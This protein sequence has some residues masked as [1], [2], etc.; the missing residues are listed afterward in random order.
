MRQFSR[1]F[2]ACGLV[3]AALP[4]ALVLPAPARAE[5]QVC[6]AVIEGV[7]VT[8]GYNDESDVWS[9]RRERWLLEDGQCPARV[10]IAHMA[11]DLTEQERG[12]FCLQ[13]DPVLNG[14]SGLAMGAR[15]TYGLCE[16]TG[17]VCELVNETAAGAREVADV[18]VESGVQA[19]RHNSGAVIL[20]GSG[21]GLAASLSS[22]GTTMA[23]VLA[24]P[25]AL[26]GAAAS[27]VVVGGAVWV[28]AE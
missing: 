15:D 18:A 28:C 7:A 5:A 25:A 12:V 24:A 11:P 27:V 23:G 6:S 13:H 10:V 3:A 21:T 19:V 17:R 2:L 1:P 20:S 14:F 4:P 22:L 16:E 9:S 26:A 8:L